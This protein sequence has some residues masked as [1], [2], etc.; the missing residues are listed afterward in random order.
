MSRGNTRGPNS[1]RVAILGAL[2][3]AGGEIRDKRGRAVAMVA[4][5]AERDH[6]T[7]TGMRQALVA[8]ETEG[9]IDREVDGRRTM[10]VHLVQVPDDDRD[11]VTQWLTRHSPT[12]D[13]TGAETEPL[14]VHDVVPPPAY[15]AATVADALLSKVLEMVSAPDATARDL[16]QA[17][18][19]LYD[20]VEE[21]GRLRK[22]L[23]RASDD[24][25]AVL[26]ERDGLRQRLRIAEDNAKTVIGEHSRVVDAEVNK[27]LGAFMAAKPEP[28]RLGRIEAAAND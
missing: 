2:E 28:S 13:T 18:R 3:A 7:T 9:L 15:S 4:R 6:I 8:L 17:Q 20:A 27:R 24:L 1:T 5:A 12:E 26:A 22:Q 25:S 23:Q 14:Y 16:Q 10:A 11:A 21:S 19:R